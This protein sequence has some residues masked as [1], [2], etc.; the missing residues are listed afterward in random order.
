M[1]KYII[2]TDSASDLPKDYVKKEN[3][4]VQP[5]FY[6]FDDQVYGGKRFGL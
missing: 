2:T 3:L 4:Y 1:S 5:L 6:N